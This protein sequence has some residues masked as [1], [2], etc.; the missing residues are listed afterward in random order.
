[1]N[2][3]PG[4]GKINNN[5]GSVRYFSIQ[6]VVLMARHLSPHVEGSKPVRKT[7]TTY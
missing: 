1:M 3:T 7:G 6:E 5:I 2:A 4:G